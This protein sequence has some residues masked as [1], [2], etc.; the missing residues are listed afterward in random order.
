MRF[1][2]YYYFFFFKQGWYVMG[3]FFEN[4]CLMFR[5]FV[6]YLRLI[7]WILKNF[8]ISGLLCGVSRRQIDVCFQPSCNPLWLTALKAPKKTQK[9][10]HSLHIF[11]PSWVW[12]WKHPQ[13]TEFKVSS[14][15]F[16]ESMGEITPT[17]YRLKG[18]FCCLFIYLFVA[19]TRQNFA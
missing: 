13:C 10:Q 12:V 9:K 3:Y 4:M 1:F 19:Q 14:F 15:F 16:F 11:V 7:L 8:A 5:C 6:L 2:N 17:M 18:K